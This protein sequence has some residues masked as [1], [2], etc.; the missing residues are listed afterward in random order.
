[1][2]SDF[3]YAV[4]CYHLEGPYISPFGSHGAHEPKFMHAP[5]WDEFMELQRAAGG[6]IGIVTLAP[7]WPGAEEF[8]RKRRSSG[9]IVVDRPHGRKRGGR[10]S[11]RRRRGHAQYASW[12]TATR[13]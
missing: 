2:N 6:R 8:I 13:I 9:V 12:E 11:R 5:T 1:M 4:P 7:E 3:A 10:P